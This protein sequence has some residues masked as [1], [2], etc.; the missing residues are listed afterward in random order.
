MHTAKVRD[1]IRYADK[2]DIY[3]VWL[4][5]SSIVRDTLIK[6]TPDREASDSS[7]TANIL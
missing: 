6:L 2:G 1:E 4:A 3:K 7:E 5:R